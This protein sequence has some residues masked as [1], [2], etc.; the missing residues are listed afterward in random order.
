[1]CDNN[2][3]VQTGANAL[4]NLITLIFGL[5]YADTPPRNPKAEIEWI[6]RGVEKVRDQLPPEIQ[7]W[8][9]FKWLP[10]LFYMLP[11]LY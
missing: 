11:Y 9:V 3:C 4:F 7:L 1:M 10:I 8:Q 6:I 2:P 5:Q